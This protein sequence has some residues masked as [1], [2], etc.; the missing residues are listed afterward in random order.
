MCIRD[1]IYY[2]NA[3]WP[4]NNLKVW[5]ERK[6]GSKWRWFMFDLDHFSHGGSANSTLLLNEI[7]TNDN[8]DNQRDPISTNPI[9]QLMENAEFT[10]EFIQRSN[11]YIQTIWDPARVSPIF[12]D[13]KNLVANEVQP[14]FLRWTTGANNQWDFDRW[15]T[16]I[17]QIDEFF[18]I[19]PDV[20]RVMLDNTLN[21]SG[22]HQLNLNF[23]A[24][25]N[26]VVVLH[27][28]HYTIP[29]N[30]SGT[31]HADV[32][33]LIHAVPDAGYR[34]SHWMETGNTDPSLYISINSN[35][36]LTPVFT[37]AQDLVINE[38]HYNPLGSSEDAEFIEIYNPDSNPIDVST[39]EFTDGI[40]FEFPPSTIIAGG[41]S[42][43]YTHLT[44]PTILLV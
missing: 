30:Y 15:N 22:R 10:A 38:I 21:V 25:S 18:M 43:S 33:M 24:S 28:N 35:T 3:D 41:E 44:L 37:P 36:T 16:S 23:D 20:Y 13:Y 9:R 31:Y 32:P 6:P 1:S 4:G 34:F 5:K 8:F 39:Y 29:H 40:C 12:F 11:T 42:V 17:D 2:N 7:L 27:S 26:G 14:D 19:R